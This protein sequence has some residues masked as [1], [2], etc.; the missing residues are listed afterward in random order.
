MPT[1]TEKTPRLT[2]SP[3]ALLRSA[4]GPPP[5]WPGKLSRFARHLWAVYDGTLIDE[6]LRSLYARGTIAAIPTRTQLVIGAIDM[7]RFWISP[8]AADYYKS[9]GIHYTF[10]QVLRFLDEPAS[11]A[12]PIGLLSDP[13]NIIGHL[14]QVVHANPLY[15]VQ[16]LA[17]IDGG[18][19]SL[20]QQL[21]QLRAGVH[22]RT[23]A[24][25]AIVEEPDYH[26]RLEAWLTAYAHD[27]LTTPP[28]RQNVLASPHFRRLEPIFGSLTGSFAYFCRLPTHPLRG[29][30]HL[31]TVRSM[32]GLG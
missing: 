13:D 19:A 8:A 5:T 3:I 30:L 21:A 31:A 16:L 11:L 10:H 23:Q 2:Q 7:L 22:P 28:L 14:L 27:P 4:L 20:H 9:Q 6:R 12:D 26:A 1:Q 32:P 24:L 18:L 15:D 17:C 29:L 25:R